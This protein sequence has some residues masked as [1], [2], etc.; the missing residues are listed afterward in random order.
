MIVAFAH[1]VKIGPFFL[2]GES[3]LSL[4]ACLNG[5][6]INVVDTL[7]GISPN[8]RATSQEA[9]RTSDELTKPRGSQRRSSHEEERYQGESAVLKHHNQGSN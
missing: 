6:S 2:D 1:V 8:S 4:E 7:L 9:V 3:G 5:I